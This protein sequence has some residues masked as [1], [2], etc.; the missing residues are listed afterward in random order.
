LQAKVPVL[1]ALMM[2]LPSG[3]A[4]AAEAGPVH[5]ITPLAYGTHLPGLGDSALK[6]AKR[7]AERSSGTLLLDL[8][9]PGDGTKPDEILDKVSQGT[10]DAGF[11]TASLWA[12]RLPAA[13]LFSGF[14]FGPDGREYYAWF[15]K[16]DGRKLYQEMYD[17]AGFKVHVIPCA[18]G[19]AETG[20]WFAK[21]IKTPD[22]IKGLRMRIFGLG[23]RVMSRAGA[24]AVLVPGG[25]VAAAFAANK[26]DAAELYTPAVDARQSLK[27]KVKLIYVPGWHQPETVLELIINKDRWDRLSEEQRS[28]IDDAC[29]ATLQTTLGESAVLQ[30][31]ALADLTAKNG[32]RVEQWP[33]AVLSALRSA[34][35]DVA[36]EEAEQDYFFKTVLD[37]ITAFRQAAESASAPAP[38]AG[39]DS[40]PPPSTAEAKPAP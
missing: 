25:D 22:D 20:G 29:R 33:D 12:A 34:W 30:A 1:L 4:G 39:T 17:H 23:G 15:D 6:L 10:V 16:G 27:D 7:L 11:G 3:Q 31:E 13:S 28:L 2:M 35:A 40:P 18:M 21:E 36:K 24:T 8:K 5:L 14:P 37:D 19:G 38:S 26:I 9:E 32:V